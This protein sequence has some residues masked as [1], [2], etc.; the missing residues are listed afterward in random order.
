MASFVNRKW[1]NPTRWK[2]EGLPKSVFLDPTHMKYPIRAR[3]GGPINV[4][5]LVSAAH[6]AKMYGDKTVYNKAQKLL[7][8]Y[9][10]SKPKKRRR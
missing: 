6:Y 10:A 9:K 3:A 8:E 2:R 7:E 1:V 5:A 4:R